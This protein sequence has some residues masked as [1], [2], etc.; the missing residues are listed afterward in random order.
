MKELKTI[1]IICYGEAMK[2]YFMAAKQTGTKIFS[3]GLLF[4][5]FKIE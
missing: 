3:V 4:A 1:I 2:I 5:L